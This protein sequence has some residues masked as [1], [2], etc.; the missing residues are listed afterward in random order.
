MS[1]TEKSD[2]RAEDKNKLKEIINGIEDDPQSYE[3]REPVDWKNLGLTD[4]PEIIKKPMDL[5]TLRKNLVK[6]R[7]KKY[8]DFFKDIQLIW[9]NCKQYN[10]QG[11]DIYKQAEHLEKV[12][13]KQVNKC[14]EDIGIS[15]KKPKIKEESKKNGDKSD[16]ENDDEDVEDVPFEK[17]VHFTEKVRRLTNEGLTKLV[18][19]VKELCPKALEDVDDQKLHIKVDEID[20]DS[21][22]KLD[23]LVDENLGKSNKENLGKD[24]EVR[25][26]QKI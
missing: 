20:K 17:K 10:I 3:F 18:K 7:Y 1:L 2:I 19:K 21:F 11:S 16:N 26:K 15:R 4:Y 14:K 23:Q 24:P 5:S 6:G 8:E 12:S 25:K 9:D 22:E 13:K